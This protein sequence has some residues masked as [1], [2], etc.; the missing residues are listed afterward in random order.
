[1]IIACTLAVMIGYFIGGCAEAEKIVT[2][3]AQEIINAD[4]QKIFN[5]ETTHPTPK[6]T[7]PPPTI[8]TEKRI[9]CPATMPMIPLGFMHGPFVVHDTNTGNR[10][11]VDGKCQFG[12]KENET[13]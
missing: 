11:W 4:D 1:M 2:Y 12:W 13:K 6:A 3:A 7:I 9:A 8:P 5:Q 10:Y